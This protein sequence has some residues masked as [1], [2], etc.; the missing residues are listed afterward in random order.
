MVDPTYLKEF[1]TNLAFHFSEIL[2]RPIAKPYWIYLSLSHRCT[3]H[4][5]MCGVVKILKDYELPTEV[6]KRI[7]DEIYHWNWDCVIM[8]T[9]GEVFL[10]Q[11]VFEL[12]EHAVTRGL[13]I[14]AVSNG[15]LIDDNLAQRII[16][17]GLQN[18]AISIDGAQESTHDFIRQPGSHKKALESLELLVAAKKKLGYGPQISAWTTIMKENVRELSDIIGLVR[19][20][21]VECLVYHPV[22]VAQD[23]MQ[24]TS[25]DAPFWI[26]GDNIEVLKEQ[27]DKIVDYQKKQGLVAFLHDPYLWIGHFKGE[28]VKKDWKCNPFVFINI[29]PDGDIRSCGAAFGNIKEKSFDDCLDT[30]EAHQ[31]RNI[32]KTCNKP[33][34]QTCWAHPASD[35]LADF[36]KVFLNKA[37]KDSKENW[38]QSLKKAYHLLDEYEKELKNHV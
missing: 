22:I 26:R 3:H 28:L 5:Q 6:A 11:D 14:E 18:I 33:C 16:R 10:R 9:G 23:D 35:S 12:I 19:N 17:S 1:K 8:L 13:K 38:H 24:N 25:P 20:I 21:G 37:K 31:A 27:I 36:T 34:L 32:M 15:S 2:N 29:G 30:K 4:C 7:F